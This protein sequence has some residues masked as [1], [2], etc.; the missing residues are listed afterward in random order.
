MTVPEQPL[1]K[2]PLLSPRLMKVAQSVPH[3]NRVID[4]GTDHAF[5]PIVLLSMGR[6]SEAVASD[7]HKGPAMRAQDHIH[8]YHLDEKITVQVAD[9]LGKLKPGQDDCVI[10]AG[11][12]GYEILTILGREP[13]KARKIILQP[14]KSLRELRLFL[15]E[16]GYQIEQEE[17]VREK[18]HFYIVMSVFYNGEPYDLNLTQLEIGPCILK[19]R[20]EYFN[21]YLIH[22]LDRMKKQLRGDPSLGEV[23][24]ILEKGGNSSS[25]K[26]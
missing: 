18:D 4:I 8:R 10:I 1:P 24:T 7:I 11:M 20:P 12:G 6:C 23:I 13:V 3:C 21:D 9:G 22:R 5:I 25:Q 16:K 14:Q 15:S 26:C 2:L 17:I 19:N